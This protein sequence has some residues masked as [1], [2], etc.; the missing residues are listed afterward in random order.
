MKL[1]KSRRF[2][3]SGLNLVFEGL[4]LEV[5]LCILMEGTRSDPNQSGFQIPNTH[6]HAEE[7]LI[8]F[9]RKPKVS[10]APTQRLS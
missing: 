2:G 5:S 7:I 6:D 3:S 9:C 1:A 10:G 8:V 4:L